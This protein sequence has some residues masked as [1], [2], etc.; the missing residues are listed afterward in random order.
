MPY[1]TQNL[2]IICNRIRR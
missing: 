1:K 2:H